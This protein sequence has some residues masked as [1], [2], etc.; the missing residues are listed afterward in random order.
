MVLVNTTGMAFIG[1][2]SEW[3]WTGVSGLVLAVTFIAILRQLSLQRSIAAF[4]QHARLTHEW[5][6]EPML[7]SR[8]EVLCAIRD[9]AS[10]EA[11]PPG[12]S[13]I[14]NFW[15]GV[16]YLVR[17]GHVDRRLIFNSMAVQ[18]AVWWA[19]LSPSAQAAR[20]DDLENDIWQDFEWLASLL[21]RM[22]REARLRPPL[23][24]EAFIARTLSDAIEGNARAIR[25][26][27]AMRTIVIERPAATAGASTRHTARR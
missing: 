14:G 26:A 5:E 2:G 18:I 9:R 16:G 11:F 19:L 21:T 3:F 6:S 25:A 24:D 22:S 20:A 4:E 15:D 1:P 27:E 7:R 8:H 23:V 10:R 17:A 13:Q 12:A